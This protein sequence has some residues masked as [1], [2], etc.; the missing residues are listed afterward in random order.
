M[1]ETSVKITV[2]PSKGRFTSAEL[3]AELDN[4]DTLA[5]MN[6]VQ[7]DE[8]DITLDTDYD[9]DSRIIVGTWTV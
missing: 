5:E 1:A 7:P 6:G 2:K 9:D 4:I 8:L 3:R